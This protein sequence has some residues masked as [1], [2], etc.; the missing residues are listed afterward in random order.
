M[1]RYNQVSG[2]DK[3]LSTY[4]SPNDKTVASIS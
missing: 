3:I 2:Y 1:K 4:T